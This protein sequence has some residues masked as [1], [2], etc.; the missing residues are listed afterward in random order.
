MCV[1]QDRNSRMLIGVG[2]QSEG[3]YL[4][5]VVAPVRACK[6]S[7]AGSCE[8]WHR[9][10]GHPASKIVGMLPEVSDRETVS[11]IERCE[12]CFRTKQTKETFLLS[13]NNAKNCFDLVHCDL[14]GGIQNTCF[15][16]CNFFL[17]IVDDCS[18]AVWVYLLKTK[19]K[20]HHII[21]KFL[22]YG[23]KAI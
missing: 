6:T 2:E 5:S 12:I 11:K 23:P 21:K 19:D 1:I 9:R 7:G 8:L 10:M 20:V 3:L 15:L 4:L 18:R 17:T 16:W 14:W 22:C 13:E